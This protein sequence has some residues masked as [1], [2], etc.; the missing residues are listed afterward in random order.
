MSGQAYHQLTVVVFMAVAAATGVNPVGGTP[1]GCCPGG[2]PTGTAA[3]WYSGGGIAGSWPDCIGGAVSGAS[4]FVSAT[5][6]V[7]CDGGGSSGFTSS[8]ATGD[9]SSSSS[10][11]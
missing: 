4:S 1:A 11:S 5:G 6:G 8:S 7:C 3:G 2:S 9:T 10:P